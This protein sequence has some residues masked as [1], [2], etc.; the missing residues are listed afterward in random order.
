[1]RAIACLAREDRFAGTPCETIYPTDEI[2]IV[3]PMLLAGLDGVGNEICPGD[4][5]DQDLY[6]AK[7]RA[8]PTKPHPKAMLV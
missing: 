3:S 8:A 2:T 5:L 6:E 7:S 4:R 1:M